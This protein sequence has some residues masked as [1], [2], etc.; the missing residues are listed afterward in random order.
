MAKKKKKKYYWFLPIVLAVLLLT[1]LGIIYYMTHSLQEA[2]GNNGYF[3]EE[4]SSPFYK[5]QYSTK[6]LD[7][8][9]QDVK[10]NVNSEFEEYNYSKNSSSLIGLK[11]IYQNGITKNFTISSDLK[12]GLISF[13]VEYT[14]DKEIFQL[15]GNNN[16]TSN[17]NVSYQENATKQAKQQVCEEA[18]NEMVT[19]ITRQNELIKNKTI[20]E[21]INESIK[22]N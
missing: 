1:I 9:I 17:C 6:N 22:E 16:D 12:T 14:N 5:K 7:E 19:F 3:S 4:D 11:M 20:Q 2:M 10:N 13:T 21:S 15:E 18:Q 8:Y